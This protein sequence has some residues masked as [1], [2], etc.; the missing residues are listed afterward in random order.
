[1]GAKQLKFSEEARRDILSGVEQLSK[2]VKTTLGPKGRNVV[3][4]KSPNPPII[5]K[6]PII[7]ANIETVII[8]ACALLFFII[9]VYTS[10]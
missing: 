8:A 7:N 2:A 4:S 3:I 10:F 6:H 5:T 1:M 9:L